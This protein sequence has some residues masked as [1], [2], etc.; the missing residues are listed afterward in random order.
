MSSEIYTHEKE[1]WIPAQRHEASPANDA[2]M[3]LP[4]YAPQPTPAPKPEPVAAAPAA[5]AK[6]RLPSDE[7]NMLFF[8][9]AILAAGTLAIVA[10]ASVGR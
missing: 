2:T 7:R 4:I 6:D 9:S 3:I 5:P 8:V 1:A 10:M